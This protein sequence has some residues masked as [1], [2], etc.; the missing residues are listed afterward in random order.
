LKNVSYNFNSQAALEPAVMPIGVII[1]TFNRSKTLLASLKRLEEQT[2]KNFEVIVADDGSTDGTPERIKEYST[3]SGLHLT[4]IYQ[5]NAG[6]A[7]ARN[8][9]ISALKSPVCLMIGDDILVSPEFVACHHQFHAEHLAPQAAAVGLTRWSE[10]GQV[11][12]SFMKW[13]DQSGVQF[14][15]AD[16]QRGTHP[17]WRHFY[18]SNLSV[19]TDLLRQYPFD[20]TFKKA[21]SEDLELGYRIQVEHG[22]DL[23]FLPG[24]TADH[25]HP[26]SF[27][28]ACKRMIEVGRAARIF[29]DRWPELQPPPTP[30][31]RAAVRKVLL[32]N[33]RLLGLITAVADFWTRL[34]CPNSLMKLALD[35]HRAKGYWENR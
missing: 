22:L 28:Q 34:H 2:W 15:F 21:A 20:E 29:H 4:Y 18:T 17:D 3:S 8:V 25:L 7:R 31:F 9:A 5:A 13:L 1:P 32:R 16:L 23:A 26:T 27:R 24:A 35:Y 14:A 11:V 30:V 10:S 12:T 33:M 6:P 19:K